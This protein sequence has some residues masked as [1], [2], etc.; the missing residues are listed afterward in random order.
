MSTVVDI[1]VKDLRGSIYTIHIDKTSTVLDLKKN[2]QNCYK[3][4]D[5][6]SPENQMIFQYKQ[7]HFIEMKNDHILDNVRNDDILR[8]VHII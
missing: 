6:I 1:F 4:P 5:S 8:L 3:I 2:I 7:R